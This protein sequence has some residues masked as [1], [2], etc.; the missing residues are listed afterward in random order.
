MPSYLHLTVHVLQVLFVIGVAGCVISV[1]IIAVKFASVLF[2][3]DHQD[4]DKAATTAVEEQKD[5][6]TMY[7]ELK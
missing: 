5:D 7:D 6:E 3:K 4:E 2:E 1:P